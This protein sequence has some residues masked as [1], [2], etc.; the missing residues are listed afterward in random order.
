MEL[1]SGEIMMILIVAL[2]IYGGRLPDVARAIGRSMGELK[3]GLTETKDVVAREFDPGLG[4]LSLDV[5]PR[6]VRRAP[7]PEHLAKEDV[8]APHAGETPADGPRS[9]SDGDPTRHEHPN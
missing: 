3:R 1:G 6:E 9:D 8:S 5:E 2:L 7:A 4:D